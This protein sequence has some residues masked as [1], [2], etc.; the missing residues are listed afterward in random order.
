MSRWRQPVIIIIFL[1]FQT[2]LEHNFALWIIQPTQVGVFI[3]SLDGPS[4]YK[5]PESL[6]TL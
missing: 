5:F 2:M 1:M 4:E 6:L 3:A